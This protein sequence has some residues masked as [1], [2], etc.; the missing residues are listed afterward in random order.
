M[1]WMS[2]L[3]AVANR[4]KKHGGGC[5]SPFAAELKRLDFHLVSFPEHAVVSRGV[6]PHIPTSH[7][8]KVREGA[9]RKFIHPPLSSDQAL[10]L[11]TAVVRVHANQR[12]F[13]RPL[14]YP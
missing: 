6:C 1:E 12:R 10:N 5:R 8:H 4:K 2:V 9:A 11:P 3:A 7:A 13:R 14:A